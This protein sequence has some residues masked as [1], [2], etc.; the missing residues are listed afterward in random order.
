MPATDTVIGPAPSAA[1][2]PTH[3]QCDHLHE[4]RVIWN[5]L[6]EGEPDQPCDVAIV[7]FVQPDDGDAKGFSTEVGIA[8]VMAA[9][10]DCRSKDKA[11][12]DVSEEPATDRLVGMAGISGRCSDQVFGVSLCIGVVDGGKMRPTI[13]R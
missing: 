4:I 8:L 2:H 7:R 12:G 3:E 9:Y 10:T 5:R 6:R 13:S 11:G 1:P